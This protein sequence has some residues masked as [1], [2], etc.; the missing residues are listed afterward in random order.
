MNF[1]DVARGAYVRSPPAVR[2]LLA[3]M[4]ALAPTRV[5]VGATY[6]SWR[7]RIA[8]AA[9]DPVYAGQFHL[10]ALRAL[11]QKAHAGSPFY[12]ESIDRALGPGFDLSTLG[13]ADLRRLPIL[14]KDI[15]RAAGTATLAV[16]IAQLDEAS[17][18][19]SSTDK[20]FR[21]YLD[22]D[23][24]A[25]EMAFVYHVWS[26]IGYDEDTAR[27]CFRGF[28]LDATGKR[29]HEW[30]P[31]LREL[32]LSVFPMTVDDADAYLDL[33]DAR[34]ITYFYG[35]PSAIELFCRHMRVLDRV[36]KRPVNGMMMISEP[37]HPHQREIIRSVLGNVPLSCFYGLSEKVLFAEET[38]GAPGSYEFNPLYGLAELVDAAGEPVTET[39]KEG[40]LVGTGFLSTGMPFIRYD[41]GDSARLV[42]LPNEAN[43]QRL[44]VEAVM[45]RRNVDYLV[46]ADGSRVVTTH[47][48]PDGPGF[49]DGIEELQFYQDQP[50]EVLIRYIPTAGAAPACAARLVETLVNR[51]NGRIRFCLKAV[52]RIAA[53]RGGKRALINQQL[54]MSRY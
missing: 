11:L 19:G 22:K 25:R 46:T 34:G 4:L 26:R 38:P 45:P 49:F 8:M 31:A 32:R 52:D 2:R 51:T 35:Y 39:G 27:V 42:E 21:F 17:G 5:K 18:N 43:G 16:P 20:P 28:S 29:L 36:P 44:R 10:A 33:I 37:V 53:G 47:L 23:R 41:T 9:E 12:R 1:L 40:R 7:S 48:V 15:L 3:P 6:R 13:L 24:S 14:S 50:G 30:D 54:D